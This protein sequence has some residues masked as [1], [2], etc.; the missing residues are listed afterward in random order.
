MK[1]KK[2]SHYNYPDKYGY[3]IFVDEVENG[4][5]IF[6]SLDGT[7]RF[8]NNSWYDDIDTDNL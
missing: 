7:K 4:V 2:F 1:E 8:I 5:T 6:Y 3:P